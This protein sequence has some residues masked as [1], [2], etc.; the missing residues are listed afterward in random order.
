MI[1]DRDYY[2]H[3]DCIYNNAVKN[4]LAANPWDWPSM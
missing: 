3:L 2:N 4:G 1:W